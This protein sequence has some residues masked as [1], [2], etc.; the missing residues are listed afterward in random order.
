MIEQAVYIEGVV[1][2]FTAQR[3]A[4]V[5]AKNLTAFEKDN[6]RGVICLRG[7]EALAATQIS[8]RFEDRCSVMGGVEGIDHR[9]PRGFAPR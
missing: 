3:V 6:T 9:R 1:S 2:V 7:R 8:V 4:G 5:V